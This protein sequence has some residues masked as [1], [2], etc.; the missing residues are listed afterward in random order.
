MMQM[1]PRCVCVDVLWHLHNCIVIIGS[2]Q[3]ISSTL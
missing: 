1:L 3:P 2:N